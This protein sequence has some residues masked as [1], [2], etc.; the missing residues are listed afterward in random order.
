MASIFGADA[1]AAL[2]PSIEFGDLVGD[3]A[4][5]GTV[6]REVDEPPVLTGMPLRATSSDR[7][8]E[9]TARSCSV[10]DP[11][12]TPLPTPPFMD[13][14]WCH[15]KLGS[16]VRPKGPARGSGELERAVR[17][18]ITTLLRDRS[19]GGS[20]TTVL[21]AAAPH[22]APAHAAKLRRWR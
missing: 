17:V 13:P 7:W 6:A 21:L 11:T 8:P 12:A 1:I 9:S 3:R 15:D 4:E 10:G 22:A 18:A 16:S 19:T 14:D 5:A 2:V 20:T